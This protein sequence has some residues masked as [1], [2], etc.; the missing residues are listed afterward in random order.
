MASHSSMAASMKPAAGPR[1]ALITGAASG[2][3][4]AIALALMK[5]GFTVFGTSR[6]PE[7]RAALTEFPMLAVDVRSDDSVR[8]ALQEIRS[9]VGRLD[10][11]VNNAGVRFLGA[12]EETSVDEAKAVFE[13]NFFG[14]HRVTAAALPLLREAGGGRIVNITSL[15]GLNALPFGS[16][17]SASKWALEAYSESLRHEV[18]QLG[19]CVSIV[20]PGAI[21]SEGRES[22]RRPAKALEEYEASRERALKVIVRGDET[23]MEATRV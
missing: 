5:D 15:S 13:T 17:Y 10:V 14:A 6:R 4:R 20:E 8:V 9:R 22:P 23:G 7:D 2:L 3:G 11:L 1:V 16:V 19:I 12:A 18:K 21:H